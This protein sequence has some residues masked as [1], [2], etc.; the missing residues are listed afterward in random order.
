MK[1]HKNTH[2]EQSTKCYSILIFVGIRLAQIK[3]QLDE[4]SAKIDVLLK[5]PF[6]TAIKHFQSSLN[7]LVTYHSYSIDVWQV[8][9]LVN[10]LKSELTQL[11][12]MKEMGV[13][14]KCYNKLLAFSHHQ[15]IIFS[16]LI[17]KKM[18]NF[19]TCRF[20][21]RNLEI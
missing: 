7:T 11:C 21:F 16:G 4:I 1:H 15:G 18:T 6:K 9:H 14:G 13:S 2:F 17:L 20:I 12:N 5:S 3:C 19:M 8:D 10:A